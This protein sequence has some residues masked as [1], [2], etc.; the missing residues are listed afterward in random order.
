MTR[1]IEQ[2]LVVL[3]LFFGMWWGL[4]HISFINNEKVEQFNQDSQ[5]KLG[6][7][8]M[9]TLRLQQHEIEHTDLNRYLD[10]LKQVICK[11]NNIPADSIT[12]HL[13]KNTEVNAFALPGNHIV[14]HTGLL[15]YAHSAEEVA[16]VLGH[17]IGH[18]R[19]KHIQKKL[20]K[21]VG[22]SMLMVLAGGNQGQ[23]ILKQVI[24]TM[25]STAFDRDFEREADLFAVNAMAA[26]GIDP[27]QLSNFMYRLAQDHSL[28]AELIWLS[29]HPDSKERA[30]EMLEERKKLTIKPKVPL[31]TQWDVV[32][33]SL[34]S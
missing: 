24:H 21:E 3:V 25:S 22:I 14:V 31:Q 19:K 32:R 16:G 33:K 7:L 34:D 10:T 6:E 15:S 26:S 2:F 20:V 18:L 29:T 27:E 17:E 11:S 30:A 4:S 28:P 13:F 23:E 5:A 9:R 1:I 12:I 8:M